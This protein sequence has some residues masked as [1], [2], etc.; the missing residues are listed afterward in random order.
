MVLT[1]EAALVLDL[2]G[3][4]SPVLDE[5]VGVDG[6]ADEL[7][8]S[9]AFRHYPVPLLLLHQPEQQKQ[10]F[11]DLSS[12]FLARQVDTVDWDSTSGQG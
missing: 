12:M 10:E 11:K 4:V 5:V 7:V 3:H 1:L 2:G 9:V 8:M 6:V